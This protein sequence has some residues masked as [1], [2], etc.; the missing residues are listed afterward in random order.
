MLGDAVHDELDPALSQA[1]VTACVFHGPSTHIPCLQAI[2]IISS[3]QDLTMLRVVGDLSGRLAVCFDVTVGIT[4]AR[5]FNDC[6]HA[7]DCCCQLGLGRVRL[8]ANAAG[9]DVIAQFM[10]WICLYSCLIVFIYQYGA[11]AW[12]PFHVGFYKYKCNHQFCI[13]ALDLNLPDRLVSVV[14][15]VEA[16]EDV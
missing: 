6:S 14:K 16:S 5:L 2:S 1:F 4:W 11:S 13:C 15:F 10:S 9:S 7:L 3:H 12:G 8:F